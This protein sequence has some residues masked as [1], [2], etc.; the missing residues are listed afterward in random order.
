MR[1]HPLGRS[2]PVG[3]GRL[4]ELIQRQII[5]IPRVKIRVG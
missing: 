2:M 3:V 4:S 5:S 1:F